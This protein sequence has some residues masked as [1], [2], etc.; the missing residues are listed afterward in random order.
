MVYK[1]SILSVNKRRGDFKLTTTKRAL[2][3]L[4][5]IIA[6]AAGTTELTCNY[7]TLPLHAKPAIAVAA[8]RTSKHTSDLAKIGLLICRLGS[9][10]VAVGL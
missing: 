1:V 4:T 6:V 5:A 8:R 3:T 10:E 9:S 7:N 2:G